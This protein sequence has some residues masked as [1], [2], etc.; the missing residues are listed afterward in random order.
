M[1][2]L[3]SYQYNGFAIVIVDSFLNL[4]VN[5]GERHT[6]LVQVRRDRLR[7][8]FDGEVVADLTTDYHDLS[9]PFAREGIAFTQALGVGSH[10][11]ASRS[12]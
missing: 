2:G 11:A 4:T 8:L 12:G 7:A 5:A 1:E 9:Q 10:R 6:S 3:S